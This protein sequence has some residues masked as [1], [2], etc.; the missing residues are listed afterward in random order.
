MVLQGYVHRFSLEGRRMQDTAEI[1]QNCPIRPNADE[2][3]EGSC[4][5]VA[6]QV[7]RIKGWLV[8]YC[9]LRTVCYC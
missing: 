7:G 6:S 5:N 4:S 2:S 3:S 9:I 8:M 1:A